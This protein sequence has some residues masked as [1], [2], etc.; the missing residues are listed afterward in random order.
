MFVGR[1]GG[2]GEGGPVP[3]ANGTNKKKQPRDGT[4]R[5]E[6]NGTERRTERTNERKVTASS[7]YASNQVVGQAVIE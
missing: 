4:E 2:G 5:S 6:R 3:T 1:G 7:A